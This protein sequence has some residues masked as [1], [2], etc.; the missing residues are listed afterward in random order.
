MSVRVMLLIAANN[1][2]GPVKGVFQLIENMDPDRFAIRLYDF[3]CNGSKENLLLDA[4]RER[5]IPYGILVQ[6]NRSY[7]SLVRQVVREIRDKKYDVLQTHGFKPTFLGFCA[8]LLCP[9]KWVCF[10]HGTTSEN[11]KVRLYNL[12]DSILQRRAHRTVLVSE[13]Q[14][15]KVLGGSDTRR[16]RVLH[17]AVDIDNPMPRSEKPRPVRELFGMPAA[18][19][20]VVS[21]GRFS[22]EKGMDILLEAFVLLVREVKDVHL[23][24]VGDGQE[25]PALEAQVARLGLGGRVHFAGY[26]ETPGDYV[27]EADV[28]VLPSRS[29][30]IPNA[31]LEAMAMGKPVVATAV[32]GVPEVIEDGV[33]GRLVEAEQPA[34]LA[35]ALA[36]VLTD[37][38]LSQRFVLG[39][40]RRVREAFS[41]EAR[42]ATLQA[43]Y[44]DVLS[45]GR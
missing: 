14:R 9:V 16:V 39:G 35:Q 12:V 18:G 30:G 33:S 41:V 36:E 20:I 40:R 5:G 25:R 21:V 29:E 45:G 3:Q 28:L 6:K 13:A 15:R 24:L 11:F 10:M 19:R 27:A 1:V 38:E 23:L 26:S 44:R 7:L 32:G 34:P 17:N 4:V 31:V 2:S 43:I 22:P 37:R 42:V 8:R